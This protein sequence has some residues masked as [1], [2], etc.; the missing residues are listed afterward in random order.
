MDIFDH[1]L[2]T[3]QRA[4][5]L[6]MLNQQII[7]SNLANVDTP[8]YMARKLNFEA[9]MQRALDGM[10]EA[11]VIENSPNPAV[12]LDGNNVDLDGELG[13]LGR[14]RVLYQAMAQIMASKLRQ[15]S[16]VL[17]KEP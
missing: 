10:D 6:R 7:A 4:M 12:S 15:V 3:L 14:N 8:G 16:N 11:A 9:S 1:S 17:D 2:I 13:E 5:D